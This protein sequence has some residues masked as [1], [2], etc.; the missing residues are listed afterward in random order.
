MG[1]AM[2]RAENK[3]SAGPAARMAAAVAKRMRVKKGLT[4]DQLGARMGYTGAAVSAMET[5]S[6]PVSDEMLVK[7]E[8]VLGEGTGIFEEMRELVRLEKLPQKFRDYAPIEQRAVGLCL[9]A[10]HVVHGLFQTEAYAQALIA[11][12]HPVPIPERV[13]ELVD[14]R[15]ARKVLFDRQP[16]CLIELVLDESVLR[17]PFGSE[18]IM[19]E[20]LLYL[21]G[22]A[23]R[24]NVY[25]QVLPLDAG[26]CGEY[27]GDRGELNLVETP[28]HDRL[29]Y[30][31]VQDESMLISDPAKVSTYAQRYAKIRAQALG[32]RESLGLIERLAGE[33]R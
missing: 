13:T 5:L 6:Q 33:G 31:D 3:E 26:L 4:Q 18:E 32:P 10:H 14:M 7:L 2:A 20:Q 22:R 12:G 19:R 30:L 21:A 8:E 23:R 16:P 27:A 1:I 17:R 28:E 25:L 24:R 11:G 15:M 29:A 9:Y